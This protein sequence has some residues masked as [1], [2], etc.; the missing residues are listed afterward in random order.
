MKTSKLIFLL[1]G[2]F[3]SG[4]AFGSKNVATIG[5]TLPDW[6]EGMLDIHAVNTARGECTFFILPDGTT[7]VV[8]A[9][10][11][12]QKPKNYPI[13]KQR[14]DDATRPADT[15]ANYIRHFSP[16][17]D[18]ID[19]FMLS[20]FHAD[21][22]GQLCPESVKSSKGDYLESGVT[23]LYDRIPFKTAIDRAYPD[24]DAM[25]VKARSEEALA[26]YSKFLDCHIKKGDL[27]AEA[28]K[29]GSD[30]QIYLKYNGEKYP[31]FKVRNLCANG[32]VWKDG[33]EI[34]SYDAPGNIRE[35]GASCGFLLSYGDFDYLTA[36]DLNGGSTDTQVLL[37][38]AI[39]KEIEAAKSNHHL[40]PKTM[41]Q[42][43]MDILNP[44]V[45]VTQS[46]N[47]RVIQPDQNII[48]QIADNNQTHQYFTNID[49]SLLEEFPQAYKACAG[50]NGHVVIRVMPGG[51]EFYVIMLDDTDNAY[52][53]KS[54]DGP[55][56]SKK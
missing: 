4:N 37:A 54:I 48:A 51:K 34:N 10:E 25:K 45:M 8:D 28:L 47:V 2:A 30:D 31:D 21:H 19:Y 16:H 15:Y 36:G 41:P 38:Q 6:Q 20:H 26:N 52:R 35:N 29:L 18:Y 50:V 24:F 3:L 56:E 7:L 14:P 33:K 5:S 27:K 40:S 32:Y 11:I 22:M 43:M 9:G 53:V 13:D 23:A 46:F 44:Q 42:E 55:Y 49:T 39:G 17:K 12:T 1:V